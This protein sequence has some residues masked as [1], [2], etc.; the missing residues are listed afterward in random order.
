MKYATA[1]I[2]KKKNNKANPFS[3]NMRKFIQI[4]N[5]YWGNI[6]ELRYEGLVYALNKIP[7]FREDWR[8]VVE[9][10]FRSSCLT[11]VDNT[12]MNYIWGQMCLQWVPSPVY[13]AQ[14]PSAWPHKTIEIRWTQ[15]FNVV[16]LL[17]P[18]L[19]LFTT[20]VNEICT[21]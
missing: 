11:Q 13:T 20:D 4:I 16:E 17:S 12:M 18:I 3:Q 10:Y 1:T 6:E 9:F 19:R 5:K 21:S 14:K 8:P 7:M 15:S 2:S